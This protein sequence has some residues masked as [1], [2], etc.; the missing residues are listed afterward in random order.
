[1]LKVYRCYI[2]EIYVVGFVLS[3]F[4]LKKRSDVLDLFFELFIR[5]LEEGFIN[6]IFVNYV[7][8]IVGI[9]LGLIYIRYFLFCWKGDYNG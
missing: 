1:M 8:I 7:V 3:Y 9:S 5:D 2:D 4:I 6:G